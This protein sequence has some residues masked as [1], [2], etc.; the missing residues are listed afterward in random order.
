M[1]GAGARFPVAL[2]GAIPASM[3]SAHAGEHADETIALT[4][5]D[6]MCR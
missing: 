5:F 1:F 4:R 2:D 3:A 6:M